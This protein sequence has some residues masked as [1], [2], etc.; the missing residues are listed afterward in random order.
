MTDFRI[1]KAF[2]VNLHPL[3]LQLLKK[4]CG[5]LQM[6]LG[7][8][9]TQMERP[10]VARVMQPVQVC[11]GVMKLNILVVFCELGNFFCFPC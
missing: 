5:C 1:L 7:L 10:L 8:N 11:L 4:W 3:K 9:V 2:N 6:S